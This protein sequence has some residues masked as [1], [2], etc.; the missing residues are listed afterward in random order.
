MEANDGRLGI[1]LSLKRARV[2]IYRDVFR[3]L[4]EPGCFRFLIDEET[5]RLAMQVCAFGDA[6][7]HVSP[8]YSDNDPGWSSEITSLELVEV[9]WEQGDWDAEGTYRITGIL[10]PDINVVMFELNDAEKY[11]GAEFT[12]S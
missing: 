1:S 2:R 9:I 7:F 8:D 6:G 5:N 3:A 12:M 10:C 4:G 11:S